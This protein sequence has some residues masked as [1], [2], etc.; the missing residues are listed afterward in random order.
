MSPQLA[1]AY[2]DV[3]RPALAALEAGKR[4]E[5]R[6]IV[7]PRGVDPELMREFYL[8]TRIRNPLSTALMRGDLS[9]DVL[10]L[11]AGDL[12]AIP[13]VGIKSVRE[14]MRALE[15]RLRDI[16]EAGGDH[17]LNAAIERGEL[18]PFDPS[19][20]EVAWDRARE[21]LGPVLAMA[22]R[23]GRAGTLE[24]VLDPG[25]RHLAALMDR[26]QDLAAISLA[27]LLDG[28]SSPVE[29]L[30]ERCRDLWDSLPDRE[31]E[32]VEGR[33]IR[34]DVTLEA[35]GRR[36]GVTRERVRQIQKRV[37]VRISRDIAPH[38]APIAAVLAAE[39]GPVCRPAALEEYLSKLMGPTDDP[40]TGLARSIVR[41]HLDYAVNRNVCLDAEARAVVK[42]LR[43]TAADVAD[44]AGLVAEE[45]LRDSLPGEPWR[46]LWPML[47]GVCGLHELHGRLALRNSQRARAK[48]ALLAIGSPAVAE[49][50]AELCGLSKRQ[51]AAAL[52]MLPGIVKADMKRW[53]LAEWVEEE[54]TSIPRKIIESIQDAGGAVSVRRLVEELPRRFGVKPESVRAYVKTPR[55]RVRNGSVSIADPSTIPLRALDE[56]ISGRDDEGHPYW[57]F[58]VEA[59]FFN[60]YSVPH[61]PAELAAH[62]G[63]D[64]D[65]KMRIDLIRPEGFPPLSVRWPLASLG[66]A[67]LGHVAEPLRA[68]RVKIGDRVRFVVR[69]DGSAEL[70]RAVQPPSNEEGVTPDELVEAMKRRRQ[71]L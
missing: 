35:V 67:T 38:A 17:A 20:D 52:S 11:C 57:S 46:A 28:S 32:V 71:V 31:H 2:L 36:M 54:Y 40:G 51:A 63:C 23:L 58:V 43:R 14:L 49:E 13:N 50:V 12:L 33:I 26:T 39:I 56:A 65:T 19:P 10:P 60:G 22:R 1:A 68:L 44:D 18:F 25:L 27:D 16:A 69:S 53:S 66:G 30:L 21:A 9:E 62:A 5:R 24:D 55:F 59:R 45:E 37:E 7:W 4:P 8:P 15:R 29:D 64:P 47:R 70:V 48:A 42:A 34:A 3:I 6:A 41:R 61:V